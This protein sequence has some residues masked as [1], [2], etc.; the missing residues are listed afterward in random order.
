MLILYHMIKKCI[1]FVF[2]W[3]RCKS[4]QTTLKSPRANKKLYNYS[5]RVFVSRIFEEKKACRQ[6]AALSLIGQI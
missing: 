4:L 3:P 2:D 6:L 1:H 5:K